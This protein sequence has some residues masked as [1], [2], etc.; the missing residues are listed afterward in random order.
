[1]DRRNFLTK[2]AACAVSAAIIPS[3]VLGAEAPSKRINVGFIG[4]GRQASAGVLST[5]HAA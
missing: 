4:T 1:M 3:K 5:G 2:A